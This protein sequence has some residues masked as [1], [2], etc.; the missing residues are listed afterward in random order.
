MITTTAQESKPKGENSHAKVQNVVTDSTVSY[1]GTRTSDSSLV[2]L[3]GARWGRTLH[4]AALVQ[5]LLDNLPTH[6]RE[7]EV[8]AVVLVSQ[9]RVINA[10]NM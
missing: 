5:N 6:I 10:Q 3:S 1:N 4:V 7:P 2:P 9:L 8:T